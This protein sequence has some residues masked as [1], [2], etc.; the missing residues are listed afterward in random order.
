MLV[1]HP[2]S[3]CD[4]CLDSYAI[5][6]PQTPHAIPCGHI[7]CGP[8]L[9]AVNPSNCPLCRKVFAPDRIKRLHVDRP[10]A[11]E[12]Q[13]EV[14]LLQRIALSWEAPEEQLVELTN[15]VEAWLQTRNE[16]ASTPLRRAREAL[17]NYQRYK[18][19]KER[20][21][22]R[23]RTLETTLEHRA[24][25]ESYEK[26]TSAA[27][28]QSLLAQ[29]EQL[30]SCVAQYE[31]EL[32]ALRS[33]LG[34]FTYTRNPLPPPPEPVPL[35]R[36][37]SFAQ[38]AASGSNDR[39]TIYEE[40]LGTMALYQSNG[41]SMNGGS[42]H[43]LTQELAE[44]PGTR[45]DRKGKGKEREQPYS[46]LKPPS[47]PHRVGG[48]GSGPANGNMIMPGATPNRRV[49]PLREVVDEGPRWSEGVNF[50]LNPSWS[51]Q[52]PD[53]SAGSARGT[54]SQA[55]TAAYPPDYMPGYQVPSGLLG[56]PER[57]RDRNLMSG[58]LG[59]QAPADESSLSQEQD[60]SLVV[61]GPPAAEVHEEPE[62]SHRS[63]TLNASTG[64]YPSESSLD[65]R[66]AHSRP[67]AHRR[68]TEDVDGHSRSH[69]HSRDRDRTVRP[70]RSSTQRRSILPPVP[71]PNPPVNGT[72]GRR[73]DDDRHTTRNST[74]SFSTWGTINT[75][76]SSQNSAAGSMSDLGLHTFSN[77][78][79][80]FPQRE[81]TAEDVSAPSL[82]DPFPLR[83]RD[84]SD[85]RDN[86]PR[87]PRVRF[88]PSAPAP[89]ST[90]LGVVPSRS[91]TQ[92][93]RTGAHDDRSA[94]RE[95]SSRH[96]HSS[97]HQQSHQQSHQQLHQQPPQQS[98]PRVDRTAP[99]YSQPQPSA[100]APPQLQGSRYT[101]TN[102]A[103][104]EPAS[105][106]TH[107]GNSSSSLNSSSRATQ[108][109]RSDRTHRSRRRHHTHISTEPSARHAT[110]T[111]APTAPPALPDVQF[112]YNT[113]GDSGY[114][115]EPSSNGGGF[116]NA[117][118]L[119]LS[120]LSLAE[121]RST[122]PHITAP[123][124]IVSSRGFLR[125]WSHDTSI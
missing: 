99:P 6:G 91:N 30:S 29:V 79:S 39:S 112:G 71:D 47:P 18:S 35:D 9:T 81:N 58:L 12:D 67:A 70:R 98:H 63:N 84:S 42:R 78:P 120:S 66:N 40:T 113:E 86:D 111:A 54:H 119:D 65:T 95:R 100:A 28:E 107:A 5:D 122:I 74:E 88:M 96:H 83:E 14:D 21:R 77:A 32:E 16:D 106:T 7:F 82:Y 50:E 34:Q 13:Q 93:H 110:A 52:N 1:L 44:D 62:P 31:S 60:Q 125:S 68:H 73:A 92:H 38:A 20:D 26:D 57:E 10:E 2:S 55:P 17:G 53:P 105:L 4:V 123:T 36:F 121:P 11:V 41:S 23:I 24:N 101:Q 8:C 102:H 45:R 25:A 75:L 64:R 89:I 124:P 43:D 22:R 104:Q 108:H 117:L 51:P 33:E 115:T 103:A 59:M 37:P 80:S 3:R 15:E 97:H 48:N 46:H 118:G 69:D 109:D 49:V 56:I 94:H 87:T 85:D 116:G 19:R 72:Q 90:L 76:P 27:V 114:L 61:W